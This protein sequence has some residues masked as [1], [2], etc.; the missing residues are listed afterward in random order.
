MK[1]DR[2]FITVIC[3]FR[4]HLTLVV[5][6][7]ERVPS[8]QLWKHLA[9]PRDNFGGPN[10]RR[11]ATGYSGQRPRV[12]LNLLPCVGQP[13]TKQLSRGAGKVRFSERVW[14]FPQK[15]R[16]PGFLAPGPVLWRQF[17]TAWG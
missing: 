7:W 12:L 5:L 15:Q 3:D 17:S 13:L 1:D 4:D 14:V 11:G 6:R 16:S 2:A 8:L 9:M 10:G